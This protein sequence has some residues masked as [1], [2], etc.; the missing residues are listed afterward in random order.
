MNEIYLLTFH[1]CKVPRIR[2]EMDCGTLTW[3]AMAFITAHSTSVKSLC[4][5]LICYDFFIRP[6]S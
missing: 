3:S 5:D 4:L 6:F 2:T 1:P